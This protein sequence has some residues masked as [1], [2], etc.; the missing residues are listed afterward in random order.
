VLYLAFFTLIPKL[1]LW[2]ML[3]LHENIVLFL[4]LR[5]ASHA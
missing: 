2:K 5:F 3:S 4:Q 1:K